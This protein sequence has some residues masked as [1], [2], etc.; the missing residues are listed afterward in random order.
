METSTTTT[1][2]STD[3]NSK[4]KKIFKSPIVLIIICIIILLGAL[5]L[6]FWLMGYFDRQ[7]TLGTVYKKQKCQSSDSTCIHIKYDILKEHAVDKQTIFTTEYTP[8]KDSNVDKFA[9]G[10][11]VRMYYNKKNPSQVLKVYPKGS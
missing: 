10:D 7:E 1:T 8:K 3:S 5:A 9:V 6:L 4:I 2:T 11:T